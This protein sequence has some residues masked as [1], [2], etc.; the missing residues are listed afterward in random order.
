[1]PTVNERRNMTR[2]GLLGRGVSVVIICAFSGA[3]SA[4]WVTLPLQN[5]DFSVMSEQ[6]TGQFAAGWRIHNVDA[7]TDGES[8]KDCILLP[9]G[10]D[11]RY[12]KIEQRISIKKGAVKKLRLSVKYR[13]AGS[14]GEITKQKH[15]GPKALIYCYNSGN[16]LLWLKTERGRGVNLRDDARDWT[17]AT[18]ELTCHDDT[19]AVAAHVDAHHPEFRALLGDVRFEATLANGAFS[20]LPDLP[21]KGESSPT[22]GLS[23]SL[24]VDNSIP[25]EE[26]FYLDFENGCI[27]RKAGGEATPSNENLPALVEGISGFGATF[28]KGRALRFVEKGNIDKA[29]GSIALWLKMP[30]GPSETGLSAWLQRACLFKEQAPSAPG[31]NRMWI[32]FTEAMNLRFDTGDARST[33]LFSDVLDW[34]KDEWRHVIVTWDCRYGKRFYI[35]GRLAAFGANRFNYY[36]FRPIVWTPK[37]LEFFFIGTE[38][39]KGGRAFDGVLDEFK[40]FNRPLTAEEARAEFMRLGRN[41][42]KAVPLDNYVYAWKE[43]QCRIAI[44]NLTDSEKSVTPKY[45][46]SGEDGIKIA[47]GGI[48]RVFV[49]PEKRSVIRIPLTLPHPG[50]YTLS[51]DFG[52]KSA[53]KT[54]I[55]IMALSQKEKKVLEPVLVDEVDLTGADRPVVEAGGVEVVDSP[56]GVYLEAGDLHNDR[57]AVRVELRN[58]GRPHLAVIRYPD[59]KPRTMEFIVQNLVSHVGGGDFKAQ[60]G[61]Y[62]GGEYPLSNKMLEHRILFWPRSSEQ[63]VIIM[64]VENG[65][66]AAIQK[67]ELYEMPEDLPELAVRAYRGSVPSRGIG[68]YYEDPVL[69]SNFSAGLLF[70]DFGLAVDRMLDYMKWFGQNTLQYPISWYTGPLYRG[71]AAEP[72]SPIFCER[73]HPHNFPQYLMKRLHAN[74]MRF[75]GTVNHFDLPSLSRYALIDEKRVLAGEETVVNVRWDG[76]LYY[77]A[78]NGDGPDFNPIDPRV[79]RAVRDE[80]LEIADRFGDEPAFQGVCLQLSRPTLLAFFSL[81]NGYNNINLRRFQKDT[82]LTIP[83]DSTDGGRF[84]KSYKWLMDNAREEWIDWR[85]KMIHSHYRNLADIL[86]AKR[87]DLKLRVLLMQTPLYRAET[88]AEELRESGIDPALYADDR[89]IVIAYALLPGD[90]RW[91][92]SYHSSRQLGVENRRTTSTSPEIMAPFR[93]LPHAD[94]VMH[95]RYYEDAI[96]RD[97]PLDMKALSP[98]AAPELIWRVSTL[99]GNTI[100]GLESYVQGLNNLD[101]LNLLKGG[102]VVGTIGIEPYLRDFTKAYRAL[103]AVR[104]DDVEELS[105]PVRVRQKLVDGTNY[106]YVLNRLPFPANANLRLSDSDV[107]DLVSGMETAAVD[108]ELSLEL[109]P[110]DL[111]SFSGAVVAGGTATISDDL[112]RNLTRQVEESAAAMR[113]LADDGVD[114]SRFAPYLKKARECISAGRHARLYFLLQE[115]WAQDM[116]RL[117]DKPALR[118]FFSLDAQTL[119]TP[120]TI[121]ATKSAGELKFDGVIS[122]PDWKRARPVSAMKEFLD[123][124][125]DPGILKPASEKAEVRMLYDEDVLYIAVSCEDAEPEKII[126]KP[127]LEDSAIWAEDDSLEIFL[128]SPAMGRVGHGQFVVNA[129]GSMSDLMSSALRWDTEWQAASRVTENGWSTEVAIPFKALGEDLSKDSGWTFNISRTRRDNPQ[130]A[131]VGTKDKGWKCEER[132]LNIVF[133]SQ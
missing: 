33:Y 19:V 1:L 60:T 129:G 80:I 96:G 49:S 32:F 11:T 77:R 31:N 13:F 115:A 6:K 3:V 120:E 61:V 59:D 39:V 101:A 124:R 107:T 109:K 41:Q 82:G 128:R 74:D 87:A 28:E 21:V 106:F 54:D 68:L 27:A 95:D 8:G 76:E 64:T 37:E 34:R 22:S 103:P 81:R 55:T 100:H 9:H 46:L 5:H 17:W 131:L 65:R 48:D 98:T 52:D 105:D 36:T 133:K 38:N 63:A 89:N 56:I 78:W 62:T 79:E 71:S 26:L 2:M 104:F 94:A 10:K 30:F 4:D 119:K 44:Y 25:L 93:A 102:F 130:S 40:I 83:V 84:L 29:R 116:K 20:A 58:P 67:I 88:Y 18:T 113:T 121:T 45:K 50:E 75:F 66:P 127:G 16:D 97:H 72:Y 126:V 86:T 132:F 99:N 122:E 118:G 23:G 69:F 70:P 110:Y 53:G 12:S 91:T 14:T 15:P 7:A 85:C 92:R 90:Y 123:V 42:F 43:A 117:I 24:V 51:I 111:R 125:E 114:V 35:D 57:F 112:V 73:V 108:E 47:S